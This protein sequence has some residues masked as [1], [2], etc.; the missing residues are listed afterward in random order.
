[1]LGRVAACRRGTTQCR[2]S[3]LP[4]GQL[5]MWVV[6]T[7]ARCALAVSSRSSGHHVSQYAVYAV[8]LG[9]AGVRYGQHQ[10]MVSQRNTR[11]FGGLVQT[12]CH[13]LHGRLQRS[14]L[15]C[16]WSFCL[17]KF[18]EFRDPAVVS[19]PRVHITHAIVSASGQTVSAK[20]LR[21]FWSRV[22]AVSA[23]ALCVAHTK[24]C[25]CW[26]T[27]SNFRKIRVINCNMKSASLSNSFCSPP[28]R[29]A[30]RKRLSRW[31]KSSSSCRGPSLAPSDE[32]YDW[33]AVFF[34]VCQL[35]GL[36]TVSSIL[37]TKWVNQV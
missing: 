27:M 3:Y 17:Q 19:R 33:S 7:G 2:R 9:S 6:A 22:I 29:D 36:R 1:M 13:Y 15:D 37:L 5:L 34:E 20:W 31:S 4:T 25:S 14:S 21:Q 26:L 11:M 32:R 16:H 28:A 30:I 8:R 12:A 35:I 10:G 24:H 23:H 18:E